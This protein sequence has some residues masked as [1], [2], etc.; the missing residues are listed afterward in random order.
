[1]TLAEHLRFVSAAS[2]FY[3]RQRADPAELRSFPLT[4]KQIVRSNLAEMLTTE[5]GAGRKALAG[6]LLRP[7]DGKQDAHAAE[8][9]F[10]RDIVIEQTSGTSGI[11]AR[12]PK[13]LAERAELSVT[14]FSQRR[15][16]DPDLKVDQL[17]PLFHLN[18]NQRMDF[19]LSG[20]A[21]G[22]VQRLYAWLDQ[23]KARWIHLPA[24]MILRHAQALEEAGVR[25]PV[26]SLKFVEA[27]GSRLSSAAVEAVRRVF[28]ADTVNQ[29]G[30]REVWAI[31]YARG[32]RPFRLNTAA[33]EVELVGEDG[34]RIDGPG[35]EGDVV[36]TSLILKLLPLIRYRTGDR[37]SWVEDPDETGRPARR[38][39]LAEDRDIN[40]LV[41]DGRRMSG[42]QLFRN[43]LNRVYGIV[44]YSGVTGV[45]VTQIGAAKLR[46]TIN[47]SEKAGQICRL[48]LEE[49][50]KLHAGVEVEFDICERQDDP[51]FD[52]KEN[53]F[54]NR[55]NFK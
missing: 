31:G 51:S 9:R 54:V 55:W 18:W 28:Q 43:I 19:N 14:S 47:K 4:S 27:A 15:R 8:V 16:F 49:C 35:V 3:R 44:G 42:V 39:A 10:G 23:R 11:P 45:Q 5:T 52:R 12:F 33:V 25:Q 21:P 17:V 46:L 41:I 32:I 24:S 6:E 26:P 30:T 34:G 22:D 53:L 38:L 1:M 7:A 50:R 40:M 37:G 13:T 36:V 29:Y 2:P 48:F 20:V